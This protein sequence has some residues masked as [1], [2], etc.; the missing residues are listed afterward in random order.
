[1]SQSNIIVTVDPPW[2]PVSGADLRN[3]NNAL[4][5]IEFAPTRLISLGAL[6][7]PETEVKGIQLLS[8]SQAHAGEIYR[9]PPN[10][11]AI[12]ITIPPG[13]I[14]NLRF[15]SFKLGPT[16]T[17]VETL[18]LHP[19][20]GELRPLT[21]K[22]VLDLHN[23]ESDL[24]R[25]SGGV[26]SSIFGRTGRKVERIR[27]IEKRAASVVDEFWTCSEIDADRL[28]D[29]I[30]GDTPIHLVPNAIP[31]LELVPVSR[32]ERSHG[33][34][35]PRLLFLGHLNYTP[36]VL[37][38]KILA[39]S[40]FPALRPRFPEAQLV[41]AGRNPKTRVNAL[42]GNGVEV[43]ANPVDAS[44]LLTAADFV[45]LPITIGGGT[46][47]KAI[48]AMAWG[49]PVV[50]SKRAVEGL[51]LVD[52]VNVR[53]AETPNQFCEAIGSLWSDPIAY[54][55]QRDAARQHA[56]ARFGPEAIARAVRASFAGTAT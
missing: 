21:K 50:A 16:N 55:A 26:L 19:L 24:V 40:I 38:A 43:V 14:E 29:V 7:A 27:T 2:P 9:R 47:I 33:E 48:E 41:L 52:R 56:L 25:Q 12:D 44:G 39:R 46:R 13:A 6:R 45:V 34:S 30:C 53:F 1:M 23:V 8:L 51:G 15:I 49:I 4:A 10:G 22:L 3:W 42:A 31:R 28:R 5:S 36:N 11:S 17:V 35:S 37:A 20:L 18:L 32:P 54:R